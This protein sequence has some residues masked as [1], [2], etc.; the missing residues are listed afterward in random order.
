LYVGDSDPIKKSVSVKK[1]E[2]KNFEFESDNLEFSQIKLSIE[3]SDSLSLDNEVILYNASYDSS[4]KTLIVSDSPFFLESMIRSYGNV[5]LDVMSTTEYSKDTGYGLYIFDGYS[6]DEMPKDGAV[7]FFNP[8]SSVSNSG[9]SFNSVEELSPYGKAVY[10][11][12]SSTKVKNLLEGAVKSDIYIKQYAKCRLDRSFTTLL[13]YD[14]NPLLFAGTNIY[15]NREVVFA[16][17]I[18]DSDVALSID[19]VIL[20]NNLLSYTFP[21]VVDKTAYYCGDTVNI[22]VLANCDS[23]R[24]Q[25]P[26]GT[27]YY[28]DT[29]TDIAEYTLTEIGEYS[30]IVSFSGSS[31]VVNV[32]SS[33]AESE[34]YTV[35]TAESLSLGGEKVTK[36]VDGIYDDLLYLFIILAVLY[37]ADW[38][39]YC[40]EQYQLR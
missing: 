34:R 17:D 27:N 7:W 20:A 38:M 36:R 30:I 2:K 21:A 3:E 15:G 8:V 37:I 18:H 26:S 23:I 5:Q 9:F 25:A 10:N 14:S 19:F 11:N 32:Y 39:V 12:S 35:A 24:V 29:D 16:F 1:L 22:N 33:L 31:R 4:F 40:Y 13:T 6:P 28:L